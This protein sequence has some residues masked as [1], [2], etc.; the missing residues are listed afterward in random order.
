V[1]LLG[2]AARLSKSRV[3]ITPSPQLGAHTEAVLGADLGLDEAEL[4]KLRERGA[5]GRE[6]T[7][8]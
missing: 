5:F 6:E 7:H 1:P 2:W 8:G 3:P 4:Q